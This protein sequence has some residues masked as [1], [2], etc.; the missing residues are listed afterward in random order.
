MTEAVITPQLVEQ[1]LRRL[2]NPRALAEHPFCSLAVVRQR[3]AED[4]LAG[5]AGD[6]GRTLAAV[7]RDLVLR[8]LT[9]HRGADVPDGPQPI[10][11]VV[12]GLQA[13]F[14]ARDGEREAWSVVYHRWVCPSRM[15]SIDIQTISAYSK[16]TIHRRGDDGCQLIAERLIFH[17]RV[18]LAEEAKR[19]VPLPVL[20]DEMSLRR[21]VIET[22]R[23]D[24][25]AALAQ[26]PLAEGVRADAPIVDLI[27]Y[28]ASRV[29]AWSD[30]PDAL[31][32]RCVEL[33]L[34][35]DQGEDAA[36][37]RWRAEVERYPDL[38]KALDRTTDPVLV[39]LGAPGSG[40]STLLRHLELKAAAAALEAP[41]DSGRVPFYAPLS[42]YRADALGA[43]PPPP[44]VWLADRWS[45][46][47]PLLPPLDDLVA[48][49]RVLLLLDGLNEMPHT[50]DADNRERIGVWKTYLH[51]MIAGRP[52]N[53]ALVACRRLDYSAQLST[54]TLRV[55][56]LE[57]QPLDDDQ[58]AEFVQKY[59]PQLAAV[60]DDG[61]AMGGRRDLFRTPFQ[62]RLLI[63]HIE[64]GGDPNADPVTLFTSLVRAA[65]HREIKSENVRFLADDLLTERDRRRLVQGRAWANPH[66]LP[67]EGRLIPSLARLAYGMQAGRGGV[68]G[69]HVR[70]G[71]GHARAL[72]DTRV[73]PCADAV[74]RAGI[75]LGVLDEDGS[76][77]EVLFHHQLIQEYFAA[78]MFAAT[79]DVDRVRVATRADEIQ[80][81]LD[82]TI[83][84]LAIA[85]PLPPPPGTVWDQTVL[86]AAV[87]TRTPDVLIPDL[88]ERNPVLAGRAAAQ[89]AC[90]VSE[91][92]KESLRWRLVETSRN[93][94]VD[95]RVRIAAGLALGELG[96]PRFTRGVGPEGHAYLLPP[97]IEIPAGT[98][99][100]GSDGSIYPEE[101]PEHQVT[102]E[103]FKIAQFPVTRAEYAL[104]MEAGGYEDERW[105]DTE[106]ARAWR[107]G[108]GTGE[109]A[110]SNVRLVLDRY[111]HTPGLIETHLA[112]G[113]L[114]RQHY[115]GWCRE[116]E[117]S[118]EALEAHLRVSHP[119]TRQTMPL[120]WTEGGTRSPALPVAGITWFEARAFCN[121]LAAQSS[122]AV[123]LPSE[124]EWEGAARA[125]PSDTFAFGA[126]FD[127]AACNSVEAHV[128]SVTPVGVFPAGDT[129]NRLA[130]MAGNVGEWT[131]TAFDDDLPYPYRAADGRDAPE[132]GRYP[133]R[134]VR[135]GG[136]KC[137]ERDTRTA[138]RYY[139]H[140]ASATRDVGLRIA[141]SA[142]P[143]TS[144]A[145]DRSAGHD[146]TR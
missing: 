70:I 83:A 146:C 115:D 98:Y 82:E 142:A 52:G 93:P 87:L 25:L 34:L 18:A 102:L 110:R 144:T 113:A 125:R 134:I 44:A 12:A 29:L 133:L 77:E 136:W 94:E 117:M 132:T 9:G 126:T 67:D 49:G 124:A 99:T 10:D 32:F 123:R 100:I 64:G 21:W 53:R 40:K 140:V 81:S 116:L 42:D 56:Q 20:G 1:A 22:V 89:A 105:W 37:G 101:A 68:E 138:C 24:G 39:L 17:E 30:A 31:F 65:L 121:W 6:V 8:N 143:S 86:M 88:A 47:Y 118:P 111:R 96:D 66:A 51:A 4:P 7:L 26:L 35:L 57:I 95:L 112:Q 141:I 145:G 45:R 38:V 5:S 58:L 119:D 63:H 59:N 131:A 103:S 73:L 74:L 23:R 120:H 54:P 84:G 122:T 2:D 11:A 106:A 46:R 137:D 43:I 107:R 48:D 139:V 19:A 62:L 85:D 128:R 27:D 90:G 55:P 104:F 3:R 130:D 28:Q 41:G 114:S 91:V 97:F 79:P 14:T 80:P 127:A 13:D 50:S 71:Y 72:M 135:G 15:P 75:D 78:R 36:D 109:G 69:A 61:L 33:T 129:T 76:G 16:R 108:E 92:V 60:I